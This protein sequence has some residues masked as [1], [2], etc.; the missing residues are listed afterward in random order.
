MLSPT[1]FPVYITPRDSS[2]VPCSFIPERQA[3]C[4]GCREPGRTLV[5]MTP[6][7]GW[8]HVAGDRTFGTGLKLVPLHPTG[9]P[10]L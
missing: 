5:A 1:Q 4:D 6:T 3:E 7:A 10:Y 8:T 2:S 9:P